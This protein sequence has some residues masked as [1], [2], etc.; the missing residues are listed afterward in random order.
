MFLLNCIII[1][2]QAVESAI[3]QLARL[4]HKSL[5]PLIRNVLHE[6]RSL[7][8][9][10]FGWETQGE[11]EDERDM[12]RMWRNF[13][14]M[15]LAFVFRV[16][17]SSRS[18]FN[19]VSFECLTIWKQLSLAT[20]GWVQTPNQPFRDFSRKNKNWLLAI[21]STFCRFIKRAAGS[22]EPPAIPPS[23]YRDI[24]ALKEFRS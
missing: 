20:C 2:L 18:A 19:F 9:R 8:L 11:G 1:N 22:L 17:S 23:N 24:K 7:R 15:H 12:I 16:L 5:L 3:R 6:I 21:S 14:Q 10:F 13:V 4:L